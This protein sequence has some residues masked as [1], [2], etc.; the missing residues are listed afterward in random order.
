MVILIKNIQYWEKSSSYSPRPN[1]SLCWQITTG[2]LTNYSNWVALSE[3]NHLD[4]LGKRLFH[5]Y[6]FGFIVIWLTNNILKQKSAVFFPKIIQVKNFLISI[7][8]CH[9]ISMDT[10]IET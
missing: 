4:S 5:V 10:E 6:M 2:V 1:K 9:K 7:F 8:K 3:K